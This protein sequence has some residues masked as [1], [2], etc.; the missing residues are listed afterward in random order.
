L[1]EWDDEGNLDGNVAGCLYLAAWWCLRSLGIHKEKAMCLMMHGESEDAIRLLLFIA[2]Y[3]IVQAL[4]FRKNNKLTI[5]S[6][7]TTLQ[8]HYPVLSSR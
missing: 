3:A 2:P 1:D 5:S 4:Y 7:S 6:T 8:H